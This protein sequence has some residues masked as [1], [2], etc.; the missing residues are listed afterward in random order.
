MAYQH[1]IFPCIFCEITKHNFYYNKDL[2]FVEMLCGVGSHKTHR[3]RTVRVHEY[4][5]RLY[6]V[7][8]MYKGMIMD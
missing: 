1:K 8:V 3:G 2:Y 4:V 6:L 5:V 7:F